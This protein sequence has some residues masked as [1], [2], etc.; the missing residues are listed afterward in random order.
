AT[1]RHEEIPYLI[2]RHKNM[3]F[4]YVDNRSTPRILLSSDGVKP[5]STFVELLAREVYERQHTV[6]SLEEDVYD[7]LISDTEIIR[8]RNDVRL[9]TW[10]RLF[11][12]YG[13]QQIS[14]WPEERRR[15]VDDHIKAATN[16]TIPTSRRCLPS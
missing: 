7:R 10:E 9:D 15:A 2:K 6:G 14:K 1:A 12:H 5:F 4:S 8:G 11:K 13:A 16:M 3:V